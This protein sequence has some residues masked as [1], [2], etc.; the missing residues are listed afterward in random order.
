ML[1]PEWM[2][3]AA[4]INQVL[5]EYQ[6]LPQ[7][8]SLTLRK[9]IKIFVS[10]VVKSPVSIDQRTLTFWGSNTVQLGSSFT[11]LD[12]TASLPTN[13]NEFSFLG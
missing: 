10:S 11:S 4:F 2:N 6:V 3:P 5:H 8:K 7:I 13:N 1:E 9:G 12:L